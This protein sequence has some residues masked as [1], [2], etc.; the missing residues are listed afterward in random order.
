[1]MVQHDGV[2]RLRGCYTDLRQ[3]ANGTRLPP[4]NPI[5]GA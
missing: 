5:E 3:E 2:P 1:M 4:A